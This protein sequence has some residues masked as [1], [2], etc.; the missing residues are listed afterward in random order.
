MCG[1]PYSYFFLKKGGEITYAETERSLWFI[2]KRER[3]MYRE[4][5]I[6]IHSQ[7]DL[8]E[9]LYGKFL[10]EERIKI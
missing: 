7:E 4:Q 8:Q 9:C 2:V 6:N 3:S 1:I 10:E 5:Y